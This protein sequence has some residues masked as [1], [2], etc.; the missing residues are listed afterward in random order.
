LVCHFQKTFSKVSFL[1][2]DFLLRVTSA[3]E[4]VLKNLRAVGNSSSLR[5][6]SVF[7]SLSFFRKF[8]DADYTIKKNL[9]TGLFFKEEKKFV[10]GSFKVR[11]KGQALAKQ[12][13]VDLWV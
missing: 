2:A 1:S 10:T 6:V 8:K 5:S 13:K 9:K 11:V 4:L 3:V 7:V 12:N